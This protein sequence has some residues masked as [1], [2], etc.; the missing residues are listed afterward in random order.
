MRNEYE[1][2][3]YE[4]S[5]DLHLLNKKLIENDQTKSSQQHDQN[6]QFYLIQELNDKNQTM[7]EELKAVR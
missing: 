4:L 3:I 1:A 2:K 6:E 7:N 5:E